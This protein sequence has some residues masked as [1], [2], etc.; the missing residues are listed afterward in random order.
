MIRSL[1][2]VIL[3]LVFVVSCSST[4]WNTDNRKLWGESVAIALS[5][6]FRLENS[7][8]FAG[9]VVVFQFR[10]VVLDSLMQSTLSR[11][12]SGVSRGGQIDAK[13]TGDSRQAD[14]LLV[15]E[16][17]EISRVYS[18]DFVLRGPVTRTRMNI[19]AYRGSDRIFETRVSG[20][21]NMA[22]V[23]RDG[24]R[25]YWMNDEDRNNPEY[26][27]ATLTDA[28]NSALGKAYSRFFG[29]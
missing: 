9:E 12:V 16:N 22:Y 5:P 10:Q 29:Q 13:Y 3:A 24:R 21:Q 1:I 7:S 18:L 2:P 4:R 6:E 25:F 26:Q 20:S 28:A 11:Y 15:I 23:A 8:Q 27:M 17:L 14:I 19:T